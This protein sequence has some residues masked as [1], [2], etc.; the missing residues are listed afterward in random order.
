MQV[1]A[2]LMLSHM[3]SKLSSIFKLFFLFA[4]LIRL[5][6]SLVFKFTDSLFFILS[7]FE[8]L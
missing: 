3:F 1:L 8:P 2:H 7:A 4:T 5:V 6:P